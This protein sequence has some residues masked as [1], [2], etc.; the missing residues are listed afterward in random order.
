[1]MG[2]GRRLPKERPRQLSRVRRALC[3]FVALAAVADA[4]A[5]PCAL[6]VAPEHVAPERAIDG[7]SLMLDDGRVVRLAGLAAPTPPL[8]RTLA[9]W[10]R[11]EAAR[12]ALAASVE[13]K[14]MELRLAGAEPDR[15]GRL[16]GFVTDLGSPD[17][18]GVAAKLLSEGLARRSGEAA[19]RGCG[20]TLALAENG[21]IRARLGLW[22]EPYYEVRDAMDGAGLLAV[23]GRFVVAEGRVASVR[24][25][26]GRAYVNFGKRWRDALSLVLS[27]ATL[28]RLGGFGGL[29]VAAGARIRARGV[30]E[31]RLGPTIEVTEASQIDRVEGRP[32]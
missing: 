7:A 17:H 16:V 29:G 10:P 4:R 20:A 18:A 5:A 25:S 11:A 15:H 21:A 19:E 31:A 26:A 6:A 30:V 2:H 1:M 22:S 23:A 8:G 32:Q 28:R 14:V 9:S 12:A 24:T 3:A 27:E 13:G